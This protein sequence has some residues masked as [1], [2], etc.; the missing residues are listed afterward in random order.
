M[1]HDSYFGHDAE[2]EAFLTPWGPQEFQKYKEEIENVKIQDNGSYLS[3]EK[4]IKKE[5][6]AF[7]IS[8]VSLVRIP[9]LLKKAQCFL[10]T[11]LELFIPNRY[12]CIARK[13]YR[14]TI[15]HSNFVDKKMSFFEESQN[16]DS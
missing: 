16:F 12:F 6:L 8:G 7:E 11:N 13:K 2:I 10:P 4:N 15:N 14:L 9:W 5:K 3:G 1:T